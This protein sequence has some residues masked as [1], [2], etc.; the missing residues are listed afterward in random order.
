MPR[1]KHRRAQQSPE[2]FLP[3]STFCIRIPLPLV[4][5]ELV[6][7]YLL[8]VP[9]TVF[10]AKL[11]HGCKDDPESKFV[12]IQSI[13]Y[14][15]TES[16]VYEMIGLKATE[17]PGGIT[18]YGQ[19]Y[20]ATLQEPIQHETH[21]EYAYERTDG[22]LRGGKYVFDLMQPGQKLRHFRFR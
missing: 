8:Y 12:A 4:L 13:Q 18:I 3:R 9:N 10:T 2:Q 16:V 19:D 11:Y 6:E 17:E 5:A 20:Y 7:L 22:T 14:V 15:E 21:L 1:K